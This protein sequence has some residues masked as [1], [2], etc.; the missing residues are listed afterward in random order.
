MNTATLD[1]P[2]TYARAGATVAEL[3]TSA[4]RTYATYAFNHSAVR[5][6]FFKDVHRASSQVTA[7][8]RDSNT[9]EENAQ[10][11]PDLRIPDQKRTRDFLDG[12][13]QKHRKYAIETGFDERTQSY[14]TAPLEPWTGPKGS[15]RLYQRV[16]FAEPR[17][18][19]DY[20]GAD[21]ASVE[22]MRAE[23]L[24][25][26]DDDGFVRPLS[27]SRKAERRSYPGAP[28]GDAKAKIGK[29]LRQYGRGLVLAAMANLMRHQPVSKIGR[30][31]LAL[32]HRRDGIALS[33]Y[34]ITTEAN[35][36]KAK[37]RDL[38]EYRYLSVSTVRTWIDQLLAG[39]DIFEAEPPKAV[40]VNRSWRTLPRVY[41]DRITDWS[42]V[43]FDPLEEAS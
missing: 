2:F 42:T 19:G 9:L 10:K 7:F 22:W 17:Q 24:A 29:S 5:R 32:A 33:A 38:G 37:R 27:D 39:M 3:V 25:G 34:D 28:V 21:L 4:N 1:G 41:E 18:V 30:R 6:P 23:G 40:R 8:L 43:P 26:V 11:L 13:R 31:K 16:I 20:N 36:V 35:A 14:R 12:N 15:M